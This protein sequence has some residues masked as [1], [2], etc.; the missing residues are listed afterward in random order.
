MDLEWLLV[1]VEICSGSQSALFTDNSKLRRKN[2]VRV[3][4]LAGIT[5]DNFCF[6]NII[7]ISSVTPGRI[8]FKIILVCVDFY[9]I[10]TY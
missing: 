7:V 9:F 3:M 5:S 10:F 6:A 1:D 4:Q 8:F 2:N